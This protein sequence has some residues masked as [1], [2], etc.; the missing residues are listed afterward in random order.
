MGAQS[1]LPQAGAIFRAEPPGL[2]KKLSKPRFLNG[3]GHS[4]RRDS[5]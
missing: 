5:G 4:Q 2:I 1:R 3:N